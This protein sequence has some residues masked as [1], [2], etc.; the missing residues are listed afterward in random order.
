MKLTKIDLQITYK[1]STILNLRFL[2]EVCKWASSRSNF[3]L[4]FLASV[5]QTA[6]TD[7]TPPGHVRV[8]GVPVPEA[9]LHNWARLKTL[10]KE[11]IGKGV[12]H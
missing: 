8:P 6:H 10:L 7:R 11:I 3:D 4:E 2:L 1:I 9:P 12:C 5:L